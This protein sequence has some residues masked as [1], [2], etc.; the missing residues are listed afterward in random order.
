MLVLTSII[1]KGEIE[2]AAHKRHT[3]LHNWNCD[4]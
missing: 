3:A 2:D 1:Q 4:K